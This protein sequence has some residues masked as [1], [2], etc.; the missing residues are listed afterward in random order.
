MIINYLQNHFKSK[1]LNT[2]ILMKMS[3]VI[4]LIKIF[5]KIY[6]QHIFILVMKIKIIKQRTVLILFKKNKIILII[7]KK[8]YKLQI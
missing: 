2:K 6:Y 7:S 8:I 3:K 5:K 1:I 4:C